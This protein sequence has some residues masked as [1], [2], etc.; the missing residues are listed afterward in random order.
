MRFGRIS[1]SMCEQF[2]MD[3]L[4]IYGLIGGL[5]ST[6]VMTLILDSILEEVASIWCL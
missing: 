3:M 5:V 6:V 1:E 4:V 2:E